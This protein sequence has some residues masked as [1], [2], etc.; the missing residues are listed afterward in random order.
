MKSL[1]VSLLSENAEGFEVGDILEN[2]TP[3][4]SCWWSSMKS[5]LF[6]LKSHEEYLKLAYKDI[7]HGAPIENISEST[8]TSKVCPA[9]L[10]SLNNTILVKAPCDFMISIDKSGKIVWGSSN[11]IVSIDQHNPEQFHP[12]ENNIFKDMFNVKIMIDAH[13]RTNGT[14]Y[15]FLQPTFHNKIEYSV[16]NGFVDGDYTKSQPLII[17]TFVD[18]SLFNDVL[19]I[20]IRKGDVLAYIWTPEPLSI[21]KAKSDF[22]K[23]AVFKSWSRKKDFKDVK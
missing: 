2:S 12:K 21:K 10:S 14:P 16:V 11:N 13:I 4:S 18:T 1:D 7:L 8:S 3:K 23:K 15:L 20:D 19:N 9:I 6:G 22:A 17:N 5:N